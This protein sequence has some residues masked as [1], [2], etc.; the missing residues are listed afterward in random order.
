MKNIIETEILE[1]QERIS[2]IRETLFNYNSDDEL[3]N[4]VKRELEEMSN[5]VNEMEKTL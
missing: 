1:L 4:A 3:L 2:F 5:K